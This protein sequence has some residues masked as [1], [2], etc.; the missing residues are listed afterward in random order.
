RAGIEGRFAG[1]SLRAGLVTAAA[2]SGKSVDSI[3]A[4]TGHKSLD[5]IMRYIRREGLF[6]D[7]A[8]AGIGL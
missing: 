2:R 8:A 7:N 5:M 1:H 6:D 4:Q 3:Q